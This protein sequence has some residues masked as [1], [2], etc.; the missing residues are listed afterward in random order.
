MS[1]YRQPVMLFAELLFSTRSLP[2]PLYGVF[3]LLCLPYLG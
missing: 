2:L 1:L 3:I